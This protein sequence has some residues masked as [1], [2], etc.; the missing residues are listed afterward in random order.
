MMWRSFP[1]QI[2]QTSVSARR[3][4]THRIG[5]VNMRRSLCLHLRPR[6]V[7][8]VAGQGVI[9]DQI[10]KRRSASCWKKLKR[11]S[12]TMMT[13]MWSWSRHRW[14]RTTQ[15]KCSRDQTLSFAPRRCSHLPHYRGV[16][17]TGC[18][19]SGTKARREHA[20]PLPQCLSHLLR[21][22]ER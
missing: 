17:P 15:H 12:T 7:E 14:Q 10:S 1:A 9:E 3:C 22:T 2:W 11:S 4:C 19:Y 6:K 21:Y 18:P 13:M 8:S 5:T 20:V 16:D